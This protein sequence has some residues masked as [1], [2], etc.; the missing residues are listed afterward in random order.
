VYA[1]D[2]PKLNLINGR[3]ATSFLDINH[4]SYGFL[5]GHDKEFNDLDIFEW[6]Y[7]S[8]DMPDLA[9][10]MVHLLKKFANSH[11]ESEFYRPIP[12][13]FRPAQMCMSKLGHGNMRYDIFH[14]VVYPKWKPGFV[15]PKPTDGIIRQNDCFYL[16]K[17]D[18]NYQKIFRYG[19][20]HYWKKNKQ[21]VFSQPHKGIPWCETRPRFL[22]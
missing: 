11:P 17:L 15:T 5:S 6:F 8:A 14:K 20:D 22:E 16:D 19:F 21:I 9:I 1:A 18:D 4:G 10:K 12:A 13:K 3:Y 7:L 2:K